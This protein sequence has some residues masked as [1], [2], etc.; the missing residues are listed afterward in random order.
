MCKTTGGVSKT[1]RI[2]AFNCQGMRD[3][4]DYP[5][6]LKLVSDT[7]IFGVSETW[8]REDDDIS[9]PG[10]KFY[11][12][13]RKKEKGASRG[14]IGVFIK[15][16][17]KKHIKVRYDLSSENFLWCRIMKK[18]LG[19]EDDAYVGIVYIPPE[20]SSR[21]K[22]LK[23]DHFKVLKDITSKIDSENIVLVG[24]FNARTKGVEDTL[25]REKHECDLPADFYSRIDSKRCNQD[26]TGNKYGTKLIEYCTV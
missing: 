24:D 3:K 10:Y 25:V 2:G 15:N 13:N 1:L 7:D 12:L 17:V 20:G 8:L 23:N 11:P 5:D 14:G 22:R 6:F 16:E 21:E 4:V 18:F 19:Y 9:L 26:L